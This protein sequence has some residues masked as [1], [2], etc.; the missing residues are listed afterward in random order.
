MSF[1]LIHTVYGIDN[2]SKSA[3]NI[4]IEAIAMKLFPYIE[5]S[6]LRVPTE[7]DTDILIGMQYAA[8]HPTRIDNR[9]H[10]LLTESRY[11]YAIAGS[12]MMIKKYPENVVQHAVVLHATASL[13]S[14]YSIE[15]LGVSCHPKCGS[16]KCGKC[17]L[18]GKNMSIIEEQECT[19][20]VSKMKFQK[21]TGRFIAGY[22]WIRDP[23]EL[24]NNRNYAYAMLLST[25]KRL[26]K[27]EEFAKLYQRQMTDLLNRKV[28]RKVTTEELQSWKGPEFY[29]AHHGVMKPESK[30]TPCRLV[31]DSSHKFNNCSLND[32]LAKGPSFLNNLL[33]ILLRFREGRVA[34]TGDITKC[35]TQ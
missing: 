33:G 7:G 30:S 9:D 12:H 35:F 17:H 25:E 1:F 34:F 6:R 32:F 29:I 11:G 20:I 19:L 22:P 26:R 5:K 27:D 21:N 23:A 4:G 16:C 24:P 3:G 15:N 10:L 28:A 2:I 14:L 8:F 13:D 31:F 18:G